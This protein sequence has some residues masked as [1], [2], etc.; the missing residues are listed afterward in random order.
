MF[1]DMLKKKMV[2]FIEPVSQL[3]ISNMSCLKVC[4]RQFYLQN[5]AEEENGLFL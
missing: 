4:A 2:C 1:L 3:S 5:N